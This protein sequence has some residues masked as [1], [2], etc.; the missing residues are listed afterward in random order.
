[1]RIGSVLRYGLEI[2]NAKLDQNRRPHVRT[3]IRVFRDGKL[4]LDGR[5]A[6]LD[7]QLQK[8]LQR[9][10]VAGALAI[11]EKL[12]PGEYVLQMIATDEL[13]QAKQQIATQLVQFEVVG[14]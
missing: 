3:K 2:Y 1:V 11:G 10:R 8:D 13:A 7:P 12:L 5:E 6:A 14:Q 9:I 4:I